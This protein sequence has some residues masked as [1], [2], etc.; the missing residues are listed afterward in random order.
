VR[1]ARIKTVHACR[2]R[3]KI[4]FFPRKISGFVACNGP[5]IFRFTAPRGANGEANE[6]DPAD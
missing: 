6:S 5:E 4:T 2:A 3:R 1:P